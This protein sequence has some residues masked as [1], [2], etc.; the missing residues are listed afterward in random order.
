MILEL[1]FGPRCKKC[2]KLE[3]YI[4]VC[5]NCLQ[6]NITK[7]NNKNRCYKGI[8]ELCRICG[9]QVTKN[10]H[11][12][13]YK[14]VPMHPDDTHM[15]D[16]TIPA[17]DRENGWWSKALRQG[18]YDLG[19]KMVKII[20]CKNCGGLLVLSRNDTE[21]H[22]MDSVSNFDYKYYKK[23]HKDFITDPYYCDNIPAEELRL[24]QNNCRHDFIFILETHT[25]SYEEYLAEDRG[26]PALNLWFGGD[27]E[28]MKDLAYDLS[29]TKFIIKWC[30]KC[31]RERDFKEK[32]N[33]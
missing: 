7:I 14:C 28:L 4:R 6:N 22:P 3:A 32:L 5:D 20:N 25:R 16:A 30:W 33:K 24:E 26:N 8:K 13:C 2:N 10:F 18:G 12:F 17:A 27:K 21:N 29:T 19:D 11:S 31:G 15:N 9:K 1:F 23:G